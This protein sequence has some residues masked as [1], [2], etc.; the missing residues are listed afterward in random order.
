MLKRM[1]QLFATLE[2]L[3]QQAE[4]LLLPQTNLEK[5]VVEVF[6]LAVKLEGLLATTNGY[7]GTPEFMA[8]EVVAQQPWVPG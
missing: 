6:G 8:P 3:H 7:A 2:Y 5:V 1:R 4:N